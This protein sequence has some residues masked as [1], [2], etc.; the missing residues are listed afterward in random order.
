MSFSIRPFAD[1]DYAA[2][3]DL[4]IRVNRELGGNFNL[5]KFRHRAIWNRAAGRVEMHLIS[6]VAQRVTVE[7]SEIAVNF[8]AGEHIWTESS[9]KYD[10]GEIRDMGTSANFAVRQQWID[11]AAQF[12]LT[13]FAAN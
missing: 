12:A 8:E 1:A 5:H 7:A 9:Y 2:V 6:D 11:T 13:L 10:A 3:R 4:F